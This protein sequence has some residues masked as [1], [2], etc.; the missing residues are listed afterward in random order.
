MMVDVPECHIRALDR[1]DGTRH[2]RRSARQLDLDQNA[3]SI[4]FHSSPQISRHLSHLL[5]HPHLAQDHTSR[6]K[7]HAP[8]DFPSK[9][10]LPEALPGQTPRLLTPHLTPNP[11]SYETLL[12]R[13]DPRLNASLLADNVVELAA[14][15]GRRGDHLVDFGD[16]VFR[17]AGARGGDG[18]VGALEGGAEDGVVGGEG[19]V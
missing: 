2:R 3:S 7:A 11:P 1:T 14:H 13:P 5:M 12:Q 10:P 6:I 15:D 4:S 19:G 18:V 17:G 9:I 16:V 8:P